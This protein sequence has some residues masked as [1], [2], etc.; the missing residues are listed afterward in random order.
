[1]VEHLP[2]VISVLKQVHKNKYLYVSK[3]VDVN[4][5]KK[6]LSK[7]QFEL[8]DESELYNIYKR[9]DAYRYEEESIL[10]SFF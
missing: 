10:D 9:N 5:Y 6:Y 8:I 2:E 1:M 7:E 4:D 3:N